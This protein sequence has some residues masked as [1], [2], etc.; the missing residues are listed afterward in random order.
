LAYLLGA[1]SFN[2]RNVTFQLRYPELKESFM[3]VCEANGIRVKENTARTFVLENFNQCDFPYCEEVKERKIPSIVY[4]LEKKQLA[5]FLA[6]LYTSGGWFFAKRIGEIGFATRNKSFALNIKHLL[7]RFGIQVNLIE[8]TLDGHPY[9]HLMMYHR[10]SIMLFLELIAI[11]APERNQ[12]Y[13]KM[14]AKTQEMVSTDPIIPK[15][16]WKYLEKERID[17]GL[18]KSQVAGGRD[19]RLRTN[20]GITLSNAKIYAE[21]LQ[22][23]LLWDFIHSDI[24]WE[25]VIEIRPVGKRQTYDVFVPETHNLVVEDILVHNTWTMAAHMLWV[26]FTCNGGTELKKGATCVVA[27]PYDN[28][29]RLIFDQLKTFLDNNPALK[30]SIKSMTKNPY[31]IEFKN[32]SIIRLFTAG[33]RSGSEGGSLRGQRASWLYMD[34][35]LSLMLAIA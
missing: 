1:G 4:M 15:D 7:L 28:Q 24:L 20:K 8:K 33:T 11:E 23:A 2:K 26:A 30:G 9:Y 13:A 31:V 22:S 21:N 34:K 18:N 10:S 19:R 5:S 32:K 6:H 14:Q 3:D 25:E 16:V 12:D 27:T 35:E 29:A 17:K